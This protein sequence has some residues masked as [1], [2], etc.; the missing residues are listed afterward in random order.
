MSSKYFPTVMSGGKAIKYDSKI[1]LNVTKKSIRTKGKDGRMD[2]IGHEIVASVTKNSIT[3]IPK[4]TTYAVMY[5]K[6]R[7]DSGALQKKLADW[8]YLIKDKELTGKTTT[9]VIP[10][11]NGD[12]WFTKTSELTERF[13]LDEDFKVLVRELINKGKPK[14][15]PKPVGMRYDFPSLEVVDESSEE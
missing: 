12:W 4:R 8:G 1:I 5:G 11:S 6:G 7:D 9:I 10:L 15:E 3:G 14:T 2:D 13:K